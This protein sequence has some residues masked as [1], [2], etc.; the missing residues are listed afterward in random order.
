MPAAAAIPVV[1]V[2]IDTGFKTCGAG[3]S[4]PF[5]NFVIKRQVMDTEELEKGRGL[6]HYWSNGQM[7]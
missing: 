1:Q 7:C 4:R 3:S 2:I 6:E 5:K